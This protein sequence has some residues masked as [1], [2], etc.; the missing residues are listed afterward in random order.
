MLEDGEQL[1]KGDRVV[2]LHLNNEMLFKMARE[3]RSMVQLAV[4]MKRAV[5][6][7]MPKI[8]EWIFKKSQL[9]GDQRSLRHYNGLPGH[10]AARIYRCRF[11]QRDVLFLY[12]ALLASLAFY[13]HLWQKKRLE[14][15]GDLLTPKVVAISVKELRR[16]YRPEQEQ[17]ITARRRL[18]HLSPVMKRECASS[19]REE[20]F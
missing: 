7:L 14:V 17:E 6:V 12:P 20:A 3:A 16:I 5:Q 11:I 4:Q 1:R 2:E 19:L 13:H 9:W 8:E 10:Q 18:F 15:K